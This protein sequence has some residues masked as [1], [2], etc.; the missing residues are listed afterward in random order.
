MWSLA[1][2]KKIENF[3]RGGKICA[4]PADVNPVNAVGRL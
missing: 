4:K 1:P 2:K 3:I